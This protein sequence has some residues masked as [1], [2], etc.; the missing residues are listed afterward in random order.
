MSKAGAGKTVISTLAVIFTVISIVLV[1]I[2][3]SLAIDVIE[4]LTDAQ[5]EGAEGLGAVVGL[6]VMVIVGAGMAVLA[7]LDTILFALSRRTSGGARKLVTFTF[8]YH[9]LV[10]VLAIVTFVIIKILS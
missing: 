8:V 10:V 6:I 1:I 5:K 3:A 2:Y 7:I 4:Y 9:V